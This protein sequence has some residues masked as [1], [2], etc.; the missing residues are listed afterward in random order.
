MKRKFL[1][2][3]YCCVIS[4][5]VLN[6]CGD[7]KKGENA[8]KDTKTETSLEGETGDGKKEESKEYVEDTKK[9]PLMA[10]F[11]ELLDSK[12]EAQAL[13]D[14]ITANSKDAEEK[15]ADAM[16]KGLLSSFE[17]AEQVDYEEIKEVSQYVSRDVKVFLS[18]MEDNQ[19]TPAVVDSKV[20]IPLSDLLNRCK[21]YEEFVKEYP[22]STM[23]N[24][25]YHMYC[26]LMAYAVSGG[27]DTASNR[28]NIFMEEDGTGIKES[29]LKEYESFC[30][31]YPEKITAEL[32]EEYLEIL[33]DADG[34]CTDEVQ[35]YYEN[36]YDTIG[37]KMNS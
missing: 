26:K 27:F 18:L 10:E 6:G 9:L 12:V 36:I 29:A 15:E 33:E 32:L 25:A 24:Y 34:K 4:T 20:K 28:G 35:E 31:E 19:K 3:F 5:V 16:V 7:Q 14:F 37:S 13:Y 22:S 1:C 8:S 30:K 2:I 23:Y 17:N 21:G 11:N